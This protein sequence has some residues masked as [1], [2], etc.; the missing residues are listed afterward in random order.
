MPSIELDGLEVSVYRS[1]K[2]GS[3]VVDITGP[4]DD[5]DDRGVPKLRVWLN[6]GRLYEYPLK[7]EPQTVVLMGN[8]S[9]GFKAVG[10]FEDHDEAMSHFVGNLSRMPTWI[11]T[12]N[13]PTAKEEDFVG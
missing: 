3:L 4:E 11:L 5:V 8:L 1:E 7:A 2:D 12:L 6:E 10:P 13:S 9:V